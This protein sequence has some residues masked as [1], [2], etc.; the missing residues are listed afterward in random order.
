[1]AAVP[2]AQFTQQRQQTEVL[3]AAASAAF[4]IL[5]CAPT[6]W[7][8][9]L[10]HSVPPHT[11]KGDGHAARS[12]RNGQHCRCFAAT[13][14]TCRPFQHSLH[15]LSV[16]LCD[17][18]VCSTLLR[19]AQPPSTAPPPHTHACPPSPHPHPTTRLTC[20]QAVS[21]QQ[22]LITWPGPDKVGNLGQL[23]LNKPGGSLQQQQQQQNTAHSVG[24][25]TNVPHRQGQEP[26]VA[27][28]QRARWQPAAA[29]AAADQDVQVEQ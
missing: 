4:C 27:H 11:V 22:Q 7:Q 17:T 19:P 28:C 25:S 26:W 20:S 8:Q 9:H 10:R 23:V 24:S 13:I 5:E 29:A 14:Q 15:L 12:V 6:T 1:M 21:H 16:S 2:A 18:L 3:P